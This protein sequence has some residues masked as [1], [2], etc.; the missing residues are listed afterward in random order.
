MTD[1]TEKQEKFLDLIFLPEYLDN[2]KG[3]M[4]EAGYAETTR[5]VAIL[6]DALAKEIIKKVDLHVVLN[7]PKSVGTILKVLNDPAMKGAKAALEAAAM[8]LDR[9]GISKKERLDIQHNV[10][11]GVFI[12]PVKKDN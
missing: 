7:T 3:A 12:L 11:S 2:W 4:L 5:L 6:N 1:L 10:Q 8:L 9:A